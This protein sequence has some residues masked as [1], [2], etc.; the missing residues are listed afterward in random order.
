MRKSPSTPVDRQSQTYN[1]ATD[2]IG[3][4]KSSAV[5]PPPA[6][7]GVHNIDITPADNGGVTVSHSMKKAPKAGNEWD[8]SG[9]RQTN[10]FS[11]P[12]EAHAHIGK[13]MGVH[14]GGKAT[15]GLT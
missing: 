3:S 2:I 4:G 8:T 5:P 10:V 6:T 13:L 14:G 15:G 11:T 1:D 12:H 9:P 7:R